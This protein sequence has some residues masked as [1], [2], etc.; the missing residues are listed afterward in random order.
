M[1]NLSDR[2]L[3]DGTKVL[4][5]PTID[6]WNL[7][8]TSGKFSDSCKI[9]KLKPI[10]KKGFLTE[11]SNYRPISLLPLISKVI[12]K[13]IHNQTSVFLNSSNSLYNYQ[14]GFSKNHS[15]DF[16]RFF[17]NGKILPRFDNWHDFDWITKS[18]WYNWPWHSTTK[19]VWN[20]FL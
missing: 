7:S 20:W 11:E 19:S 14:S 8:I 4:I 2:F 16:C 18:L 13:V 3:K 6:L 15:T 17:L 10:Y 12:E 9:G 5:K 1:D